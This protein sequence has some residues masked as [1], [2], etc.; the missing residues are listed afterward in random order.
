M[1]ISATDRIE[2]SQRER[3]I[4]T[5]MRPVLDGTRTQAE[6]AMAVRQRG[7]GNARGG[8]GIEAAFGLKPRDQL[9]F[10]FGLF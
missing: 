7:I 9:V 1:S 3:D 4:L 6:A 8:G 2:M 10:V 5:I